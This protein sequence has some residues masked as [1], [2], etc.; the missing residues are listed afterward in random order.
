MPSLRRA[1]T[2]VGSRGSHYRPSRADSGSGRPVG[3]R[4][5]WT[6]KG[7]RNG[8]LPPAFSCQVDGQASRDAQPA[9]A[10]PT[11]RRMIGIAAGAALG[12][13]GARLAGLR[14]FDERVLRAA[15]ARVIGRPDLAEMAMSAP[16]ADPDP[17]TEAMAPLGG[18]LPPEGLPVATPAP[19]ARLVA[20]APRAVPTAPP[21]PPVADG[22]PIV[23]SGLDWVSPLDAETARTTQLLR[24]ATFGATAA[25]LDRAWTDGFARTVDRLIETSPAPPPALDLTK[26]R[27]EQLQRWWIDHI[28]TTPTP[29]AERM[30]LFW[31]G[32]FTSDYRKVGLQRPYVY[33]QNLTWRTFALGDLRTFLYQVT[34]DPAMLSYLDL[35]ISTAAN[36]NENYARELMELYTLGVGQFSEDDVRA[37]ARALAGWRQPR[38]TD[39]GRVGTFAPERSFKGPLTFLGKTATFDT[40]AVIDR[41]LAQDATAPF[42]TRRVLAQFLTRD[43]SDE[44]V[45]RLAT[46]FRRSGY[47]LKGLLRDVFT[48]PEFSSP[49]AYRSLVKSPVEFT[50][51]V[52]KALAAT[53]IGPAIIRASGG[54][55]QSLFDPPSVGGWPRNE[56]WVSSN[57]VVARANFVATALGETKSFPPA[58]NVHRTQLDGVLGPQTAAALQNASDDR[59]RWAVVLSAAEFQLK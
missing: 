24:R 28:L 35:G 52:A 21:Q 46:R 54:M 34:I 53:T 40:Q 47:D 17:M 58:S 13:A 41:I 9:V 12:V 26:L 29:F 15:A 43:P 10:A 25:E 31:H 44:L 55:G 45:G 16:T 20:A 27:I 18:T 42:I 8:T 39:P 51:S 50:V 3:I 11:R 14:D 32:H 7:R 38:E 49:D 4:D 1:L 33:W 23:G 19:T 36:P 6:A 59:R 30:T 5:N 56:G 57:S 37:G 22:T 48:S 2:T